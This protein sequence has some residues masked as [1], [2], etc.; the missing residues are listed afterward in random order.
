M[1]CAVAQAGRVVWDTG[2]VIG[3]LE[4][5]N[6]KYQFKRAVMS[7][8]PVEGKYNFDGP[9]RVTFVEP[10]GTATWVRVEQ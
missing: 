7:G 4:A 3:L 5:S 1:R 6:G 8:P 9:D 10:R 2:V